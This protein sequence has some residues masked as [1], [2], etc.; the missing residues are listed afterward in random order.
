MLFEDVSM[1][2]NY[3]NLTKKSMEITF[4]SGTNNS[5][6]ITIPS[7]RIDNWSKSGGN[8]DVV[9]EEFD[10][11]VEDKISSEPITIEVINQVE[12]YIDG[13]ES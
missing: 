1:L 11:V 4:S 7:F 5:I 9:N 2:R 12:K 3:E 10:F 13:E 6:K 8:D